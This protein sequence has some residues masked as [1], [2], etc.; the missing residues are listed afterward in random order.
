MGFTWDDLI[1]IA[2]AGVGTFFGG[3]AGGVTGYG[4]GRGAQ[5]LVDKWLPTSPENQK[6]QTF[7]D[8][9]AA[10]GKAGPELQQRRRAGLESQL[11]MFAPYDDLMKKMYGTS[12]PNPNIDSLFAAPQGGPPQSPAFAPA[13]G[14]YWDPKRI[15]QQQAEDAQVR[16]TM[17]KTGLNNGQPKKNPG[18][19]RY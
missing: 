10:Y 1:P 11:G 3:P 13:P 15:A 14:S 9:T 8:V 7:N 16:A 5:G 12:A 18:G 17:K 6:Q 2:G 4:L 19:R